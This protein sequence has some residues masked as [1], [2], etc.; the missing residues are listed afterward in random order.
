MPHMSRQARYN[1]ITVTILVIIGFLWIYPFLW[2]TLASFKTPAEMFSAGATLLPE[3]W[4]FNNFARAWDKAN[5]STYFFNTVLYAMAATAIELFKSS[6]CGYVL[7][8]Y[9]F[10]G[11]NLLLGHHHSDALHSHCLHHSAPVQAGADAGLAQHPQ[12]RHSGALRRLGRALCAALHRL[13]SDAARR[14]L[15][16]SSHRRGQL[17]GRP[18]ASCCLWPGRLSPRWS[19]SSS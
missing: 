11:R 17:S 1:L 14:A 6:M 12:R 15:R 4:D 13:L 10:P 7:G 16:R 5:F 9:R 18:F 19:S 2:V 3:Q 8:R